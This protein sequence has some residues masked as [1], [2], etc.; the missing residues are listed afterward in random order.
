MFNI[1]QAVLVI[2]DKGVAYEGY[3]MA[4]ALGDNGGPSAYQVAIH[5]NSQQSQWHRAS[6]VFA[7]EETKPEEPG[8][9][10]SFLKK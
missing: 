1:G 6:E 10:E 5:G 9:I 8:S 2:T 7:P 3:V 4:R